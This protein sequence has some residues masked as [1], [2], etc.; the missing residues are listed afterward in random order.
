MPK[1]YD[2]ITKNTI[3]DEINRICGTTDAVYL[4]RDKLANV[5]EALDKYWFLASQSAPQ[6]T[7]DDTSNT[8][9]PVETQSLVAGTNAYKVSDFTNNVLQI[10]R[11]SALNDDA[12]EYD[13]IYQDFEDIDDFTE[14]YS[15][16]SS[17][18]GLP[19]YWTKL[20]DYIYI[21][22]CP[23][24]AETNGLKCYVSREL[25]KLEYVTFTI[26]I[27]NPGVVTATTH[28]LS[29]NDVVLLST[30]GTL[31]TGL[32]ADTTAYYIYKVDADT[33]QLRS[34]PGGTSIETTGSQTG[35]H[36]FVK[37]N[38]EPG[39]P[40]IHHKYLARFASNEFMDTKHPKFAKNREQMLR[41]EIAIQEYWQS[42]IKPGKTIIET[43]KRSYK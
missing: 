27:A 15:T 16:D 10:L 30:N 34:V 23:N 37:I 14:E 3:R 39:I 7:F 13:L 8:A 29:T 38:T 1:F 24:Y 28:G 35:T 40:V 26:T 2:T 36:G 5:N 17:K 42:M 21:S 41:D 11:V 12:D 31:P 6:G 9:I 32:T 43:A 4:L 33:F 19:Q 25:S 22:P 18:R 20:G